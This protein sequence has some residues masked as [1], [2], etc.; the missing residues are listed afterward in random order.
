[1]SAR[2]LGAD[3][4]DIQHNGTVVLVYEAVSACSPKNEVEIGPH[5]LAQVS[6]GSGTFS[7]ANFVSGYE[8]WTSLPHPRLHHRLPLYV[9]C[10]CLEVTW[11][12]RI[13]ETFADSHR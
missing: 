3:A 8:R 1:M 4:E 10:L 11:V 13:A 9:P 2:E 7:R 5:F 12:S 6:F